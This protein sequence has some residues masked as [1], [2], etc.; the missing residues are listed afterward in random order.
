M[1]MI[2]KLTSVLIALCLSAVAAAQTTPPPPNKVP[3]PDGTIQLVP[4]PPAMVYTPY[5]IDP[6]V[7]YQL[8]L[9]S[10]WAQISWNGRTKNGQY[11][12]KGSIITADILLMPYTTKKTLPAPDGRTVNM[13]SVYRSTDAVVQYDHTRLE[14]LPYS[15]SANGP[16]FDAN[17]MNALK[18]QYTVLG[19]GLIQFHSEVNLAPELRT[20]AQK[21][22][23]YQ[24]NFGG[25]MWQ[26]GYRLLGKLQFRV[27]DDY[28][29]P[30]FG[31]Q[32]SFIRLLP[33]V[34]VGENTITTRVDGSPT[35]GT[36]VLK[37]IRS[38]GDQIMFGATPEHKVS[39]FLAAPT[40]K[41]KV[42][43]TIPVQVRVKTETKPQIISYVAT[44][45]AWDNTKLEFIGISTTGARRAQSSR[46]DLAGAGMINESSVPKDGNAFHNW[47]SQLGDRSYLDGEALIV[48][49]NFK[50]VS[51]FDTTEI[52]IIKKNDPRLAGLMVPEESSIGGSNI[53]GSVVLGT[54]TPSVK[55]N[56]VF[57]P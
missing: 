53:P 2:E 20:P 41:F 36:N 22:L 7:Q 45:F 32:R 43:D 17:V 19:D 3:Q 54:Q 14:L 35:A 16:A 12:F 34:T 27:K 48:T 42:G 9:T 55:V 29:L 11:G 1:K 40:T 38:E 10:N 37:D 47:L 4:V 26:G 52:E 57:A 23:Y 15:A 28:Y 44:N 49:L 21:P 5:F 56:G 24:W 8:Y 30:T 6:T 39:H 25:Y 51:D 33:S 31:S 46:M 18:T 50:V 13:F